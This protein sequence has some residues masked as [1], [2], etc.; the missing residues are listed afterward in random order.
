MIVPDLFLHEP[1]VPAVLDQVRDV[2][3]ES[4]RW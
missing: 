1:R 3:R 4:S 2:K